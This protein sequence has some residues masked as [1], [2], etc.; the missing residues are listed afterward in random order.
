[1]C[2]IGRKP[3]TSGTKK[4][5]GKTIFI[6][7]N[8]EGEKEYF[9]SY[10][11]RRTYDDK[12]GVSVKAFF[13]NKDPLA[14][15]KKSI[16]SFEIRK[17]K[18]RFINSKFIIFDK[19]NFKCEKAVK[20]AKDN[21][22]TPIVSNPSFEIW[23]AYHFKEILQTMNQAQ[24][25]DLVEKLFKKK[26]K[27]DYNKVDSNLYDTLRNQIRDAIKNSKMSCSRVIGQ[28]I[29]D[30]NPSTE[31]YKVAKDILDN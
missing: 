2:G 8:G 3:R 10:P 22:F 16:K 29:L 28:N 18:E 31:I 27:R 14:L 25:L 15:V 20:L 13:K 1:M 4:L 26:Y 23:I 12:K 24:A 19:D 11:T 7:T 17:N 6:Y 5:Y 21:G 30:C 9:E